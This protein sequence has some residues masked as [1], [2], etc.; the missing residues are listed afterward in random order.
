MKRFLFIFILSF[1]HMVF[2]N[3][4]LT[5]TYELGQLPNFLPHVGNALPGR[6]YPTTSNKKFGSVLMVSFEEDGFELVPFDAERK[7]D[8]FFDKMTYDEVLKEFPLIK[9]MFMWVSET[10]LGAVIEN[11]RDPEVFRGEIRETEKYLIMRVI[12][13]GK[14]IK[15][16]NYLK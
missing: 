1:G 2:G 13:K 11:A 8:D 7:R 5:N 15:N 12:S 10:A 9:K 6:C 16:C 4:D 3:E 14:V